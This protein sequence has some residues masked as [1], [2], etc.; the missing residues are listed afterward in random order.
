MDFADFWQTAEEEGIRGWLNHRWRYVQT[1][2]CFP[3]RVARSRLYDIIE[4]SIVATIV[5]LFIK[6]VMP[7][8]FSSISAIH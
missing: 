5:G 1:E 2:G 8:A 7:A 3:G 4:G 6:F